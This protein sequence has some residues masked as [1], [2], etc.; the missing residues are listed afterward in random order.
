MALQTFGP[1]AKPVLRRVAAIGLKMRYVLRR[2]K[3]VLVLAALLGASRLAA[4]QQVPLPRASPLR[5]LRGSVRP[6]RPIAVPGRPATPPKASAGLSGERTETPP[7]PTACDLQLAKIAVVHLLGKLMA[8]GGCG[9]PDAVLL[10]RVVLPDR[11]KV[12]VEPPAILRC[13][14]ATAVARWVRD[15]VA[16]ASK[17]L[18]SPLRALHQ[19]DSYTCR[20]RDGIRGAKLSEHGRANALDV[21]AFKL[22]DGR[23]LALADQGVPKIFREAVR[24]G[25]C[26]RFMTVLG[27]GSDGYHSQHVH[28]DLEPRHNDYKICEWDMHPPAV[29]AQFLPIPIGEVPLP[30]PRPRAAFLK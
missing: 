2:M 5:I 24:A 29:L 26:A 21:L 4:A 1:A 14:M 11:T 19:I 7:T 17:Q 27:P 13:T 3:A 15:D 30:R 12:A 20:T 10:E 25:A 16:P 8:P 18:G 28:I 9:A 6:A 23:T 22:A